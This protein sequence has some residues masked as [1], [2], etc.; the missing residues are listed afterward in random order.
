MNCP[1]KYSQI[2]KDLL[3]FDQINLED[4]AKEAVGRFGTHHAICH[5]SVINNQVGNTV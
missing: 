1:K 2:E 3:P 5:Y 4:L